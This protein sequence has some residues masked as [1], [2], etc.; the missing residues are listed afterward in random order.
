[1]GARIA[2]AI[3]AIISAALLIWVVV[4]SFGPEE[5]ISPTVKVTAKQ[6]AAGTQAKATTVGQAPRAAAKATP[7]QILAARTELMRDRTDTGPK[8]FPPLAAGDFS[9]NT[10]QKSSP[11]PQDPQK[12][13]ANKP[14][15][16]LVKDRGRVAGISS[17]PYTEAA[18]FEQPQGRT[19]RR[20]H[21]DQVRYGGG[22]LLF[23]T[24]LAL[25]LFLAARG[26]I[27]VAEGWSG[28]TVERFGATERA[29]HWMTAVSF[30]LMA[31]TG[32][33]LLYGKPL[34]IP[35][36]GEPAFGSVAY[37]SAW[38]HMSFA[39]PFVFGI[40]IMIALWLVDNIPTRLD[41]EWLKRGGG[42]MHDDGR[43]PPAR[44]F[45]AGQKIVFWGVTLGGLLLLASGLSL[46]F[47]FYWFGYDGMQSAQIVH[48]VLALCMIA[49]IFGHVYI[50]TIGMEGAFDAMW[51]GDVDRNWA[52]EHHSIWYERV[53]G[54]RARSGRNEDREKMA[55]P[56]R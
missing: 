17:L 39:V 10:D 51:S 22:W 23:G 12:W 34:L 11:N 7:E 43:N 49:L 45:N 15:D 13:L 9:I 25:A 31:L 53:T 32:I 47:P 33:I 40:L 1:M 46:M 44:K 29:N 38:L 26:R 20:V 35:L 2:G 36:I 56:A 3:V 50:G 30:I 5:V 21:N 19:W 28:E 6:A 16:D 55:R 48:A 54:S 4:I 27:K 14:A 42:F 52:K 41:W 24:I 8:A 37:W 18:S